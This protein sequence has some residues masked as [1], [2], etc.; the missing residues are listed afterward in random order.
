MGTS[1]K[2]LR[3][4]QTGLPPGDQEKR[5]M[6][7]KER[8]FLLPLETVQRCK[9]WHEFLKR[10]KPAVFDELTTAIDYYFAGKMQIDSKIHFSR[11]IKKHFPEIKVSEKTLAEFLTEY[12]NEP[13]RKAKIDTGRRPPGTK[14]Q[15][16]GRKK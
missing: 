1:F 3:K 9:N 11:A 7:K 13:N 8:V 14:K 5:K 12:E 4:V 2:R 15:R 16:T 10:D 6:S